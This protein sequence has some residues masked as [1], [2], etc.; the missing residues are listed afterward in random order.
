MDRISPL[1]NQGSVFFDVRD[2]GRSLRLSF[3]SESNVFVFSLWREAECLGSFRL[4]ADDAPR[5]IHA[6]TTGLAGDRPVAFDAT[7]EVG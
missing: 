6:I 7:T 5:L 3:H 2:E 1:P 4:P